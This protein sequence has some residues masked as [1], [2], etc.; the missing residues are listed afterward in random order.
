MLPANQHPKTLNLCTV[1][2][3]MLYHEYAHTTAFTNAFSR[4]LFQPAEHVLWAVCFYIEHT[5]IGYLSVF[6]AKL[7]GCLR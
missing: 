1:Y 2:T 6:S 4:G 3:E 7:R 5:T